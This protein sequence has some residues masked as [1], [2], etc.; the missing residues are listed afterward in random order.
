MG[1][2]F[3]FHMDMLGPSLLSESYQYT[4]ISECNIC[5]VTIST[6]VLHFLSIFPDVNVFGARNDHPI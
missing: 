6:S 4:G 5:L 2:F 3:L 1:L